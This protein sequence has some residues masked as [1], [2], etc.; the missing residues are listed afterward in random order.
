ML[1][2]GF[3]GFCF[4]FFQPI[5]GPEFIEPFLSVPSRL[6][7]TFGA[8]R[9]VRELFHRLNS[10]TRIVRC[11]RMVFPNTYPNPTP[12]QKRSRNIPEGFRKRLPIRAIQLFPLI[13]HWF[14]WNWTAPIGC[15]LVS[16]Q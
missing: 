1:S 9:A 16:R 6:F 10:K 2:K 7:V 11:A 14:W 5:Q 13:E 8:S 12:M 3:A 15:G 4:A